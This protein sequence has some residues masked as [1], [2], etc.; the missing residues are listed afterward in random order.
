MS[1]IQAAR[2]LRIDLSSRS[3]EIEDIPGKIIRQYIGGRGLGSYLLYRWVPAHADPLG[4]D[5][6]LIFT[7]GPLSGTGFFYSS[8]ANLTTKSPLTNIYLYS[9]CS[10]ILA[11]EMKKA[12]F[13]AIDIKGIAESPTY[14][15]VHNDRVEF[16]DAGFLW[17][18]G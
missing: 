7:G 10:G 14:I 11:Q 4:A 8:K 2:M 16:K 12:G 15:A 6:H 17:G 5:N 13:W 9:I 1:M 3:F 18:M